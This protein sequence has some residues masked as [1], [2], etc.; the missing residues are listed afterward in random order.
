L[1]RI[2]INTRF[3]LSGKLEGFGWYTYEVSK[4]LVE[5]HPE[6]EF[7]FFFDRPYDNAFVFGSNVT[8]VILQ[9][10]ARHPFLFIL[11]FDY[12]LP[13]A[14]K[15][16][17]I[18]VLFSPDGY[19]SLRSDIPQI[20]TIH[21][22]NFEH[23]PKDVPNL[24]RWYLRS[25]FPKFAKK[26]THILTVSNYSKKD[27]ATTYGIEEQKITVGWN[28]ASDHFKPLDSETI[29]Y[30]RDKYSNGKAYFVFVGSI[31]PRKNL[32]RLIQAFEMYAA[33]LENDWDLVIV[34]A[35]MWK[36]KNEELKISTSSKSRIH[37][38]GRLDANELAFVVGAAGALAYVPYFEGFGIPLVEAM[39]CGVPILSG[40]K[41]SLPEVAED[42]AIYC[43]PMDVTSIT[44]G[45][46]QLSKDTALR[47]QLS[48]KGLERSKLFSWDKTAETVWS[49]VEKVLTK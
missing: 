24:V 12:L 14:M 22:I 20:C 47:K 29:K 37:F 27:I 35:T 36:S 18:D 46:V 1:A 25:Y 39:K 6:H 7:V 4:R 15:K 48:E 34:G 16:H 13:K 40:N 49:C 41:T 17:K 21:D 31:H 9:P 38:T 44:T 45:L 43:E 11:W 23:F 28:G 10:S 19:L 33:D 32:K 26:A 2:G 42:A 30:T 5:N 8:P 3:L